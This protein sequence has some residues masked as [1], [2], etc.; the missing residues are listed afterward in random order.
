MNLKNKCIQV[1]YDK[2]SCIY[3]ASTFQITWILKIHLGFNVFYLKF[4][5]FEHLVAK[6]F[7][8]LRCYFHNCWWFLFTHMSYC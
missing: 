8:V 7:K 1:K 2:K 5:F 4:M 3:I 6:S